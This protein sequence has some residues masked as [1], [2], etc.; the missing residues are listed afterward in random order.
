[1]LEDAIF[2]YGRKEN[3]A[4]GQVRETV[5]QTKNCNKENKSGRPMQRGSGGRDVIIKQSKKGCTDKKNE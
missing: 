2:Y 3:V 1:M 4:G 5:I